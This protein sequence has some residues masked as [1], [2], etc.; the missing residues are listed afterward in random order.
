MLHEFV[1]ANRAEIISRTRTKVAQRSAP[2]PTEEELESGVPL[3]LD[4]LVEALLRS[5]L[6]TEAISASATRQGGDLLRRGLTIA[7]VVHGYGD[8]C[9]A[10]TE[11]ADEIKAPI[12][13]DEFHTLNRC[14]DDAIA[15]AVTEYSRLRQSSQSDDE[16]E[17]LGVLAHEMRNKLS[18]AILAFTIL[19]DGRVGIG[20]NTGAVVE[21]NLLG[22][23]DLIDRSLAGVR[24]D[25]GL[26]NRLRISVA[27]LVEEVEID[28]IPLAKSFKIDLTIAPV[29]RGL[30]VEADRPIL[31]AALTNLLQ[32]AL[33]FSH[34]GGQ[35]SMRTTGTMDRIL[36]EVEDECGGLPPGKAED[37]FSP[38]T[39]RSTDRRGIGLGL[40]IARRGIEA[41]GGVIRVRNLPS[42]GCIFTIDLPRYAA[43]A[44]TSRSPSSR[45]T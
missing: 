34:A 8:V 7:Q 25:A 42:K 2:R 3:F 41:N 20:G 16:T 12:T 17:R 15:E 38:F 10:I 40:S 36:F 18:A 6:S 5:T 30:E 32:N 31:A 22:L 39:Q 23:R 35:V 26:H 19:Q 1:T 14:L 29:E 43:R 45:M 33:K 27:D 11:L 13:I 21:R 4:Q 44:R 28:A 37:L 24:I 9:Q